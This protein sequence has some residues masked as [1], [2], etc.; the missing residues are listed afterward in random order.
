ML[1][2]VDGVVGAG[3]GGA[4]GH[5]GQVSVS[6]QEDAIIPSHL[7]EGSLVGAKVRSSNSVTFTGLT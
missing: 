5:V 1:K 3:G 6:E 4:A 7:M 2:Q